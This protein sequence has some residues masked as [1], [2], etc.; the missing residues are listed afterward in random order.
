MGLGALTTCTW[1]SPCCCAPSPLPAAGM[2]TPAHPKPMLCGSF[3]SKHLAGGSKL[4][5]LS[6]TTT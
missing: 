6:L 4:Y 1:L 2:F 5:S 3:L